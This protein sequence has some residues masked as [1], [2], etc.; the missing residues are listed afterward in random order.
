MDAHRAS[1]IAPVLEQIEYVGYI[2]IPELRD[3]QKAATALIHLPEDADPG[4]RAALR[5]QSSTPETFFQK[6]SVHSA[7]KKATIKAIVARGHTI[8]DIS[9][10]LI[11]IDKVVMS[12]SRPKDTQRECWINKGLYALTGVDSHF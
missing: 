7:S 6:A 10:K 1:R 12:S 11:V 3:L 5:V 2:H 4:V 8:H 9:G